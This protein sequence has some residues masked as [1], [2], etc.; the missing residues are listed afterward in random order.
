MSKLLAILSLMSA[1]TIGAGIAQAADD[2]C[3]PGAP[4]CQPGA[5][6]CKK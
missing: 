2:C 3:K 6:C 1:L 5:P 4:C